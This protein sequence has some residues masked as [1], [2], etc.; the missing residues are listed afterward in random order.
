MTKIT[1]LFDEKIMFK[2]V[3]GMRNFGD[4]KNYNLKKMV[5]KGQQ[6]SKKCIFFN[7]LKI[8]SEFLDKKLKKKISILFL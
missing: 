1:K 4:F 3:F 8:T 6:N 7:K 5:K 2:H